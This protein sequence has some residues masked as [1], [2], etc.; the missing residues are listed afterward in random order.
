VP[1]GPHIPGIWFR[2]TRATL[3]WSTKLKIAAG[4]PAE[5]S[6]MHFVSVATSPVL[7]QQNQQLLGYIKVPGNSLLLAP[8]RTIIGGAAVSRPWVILLTDVETRNNLHV[9]WRIKTPQ[10][11]WI[12]VK[13]HRKGRH[14]TTENEFKSWISASFSFAAKKLINRLMNL[15]GTMMKT[16]MATNTGN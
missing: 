8:F 4:H 9:L 1:T 10:A 6:D 3:T 15:S 5:L 14:V 7:L 13:S 2:A 12:A 11:L 16:K